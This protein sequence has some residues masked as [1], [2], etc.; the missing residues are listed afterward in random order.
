MKWKKYLRAPFLLA[1]LL[2]FAMTSN[3]FASSEPD[4]SNNVDTPAITSTKSSSVTAKKDQT[5]TTDDVVSTVISN[6]DN[7]TTQQKINNR[8]L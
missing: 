8:L 7:V 1:M 6:N 3:V 4:L 2:V 5:K